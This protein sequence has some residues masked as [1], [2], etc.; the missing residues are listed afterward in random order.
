[1]NIPIF[2]EHVWDIAMTR[3]EEDFF[4][5]WRNRWKQGELVDLGDNVDYLYKYLSR[6]IKKPENVRDEVSKVL[7]DYRGVNEQFTWLCERWLSDSYLLDGDYEA[8]LNAHPSMKPGITRTHDANHLLNVKRLVGAPVVATDLLALVGPKISDWGRAN[9]LH[10]VAEL[11]SVLEG[12]QRIPGQSLVLHWSRGENSYSWHLF[13]GVST[14]FDSVKLEKPFYC[15]YGDEAIGQF[16]AIETRDAENRARRSAG[17]PHIGEGWVSETT[18]FH[19]VK[20]AF[21][22]TD[23]LHHA[24]PPWLGRQ[25]LDIFIPNFK[26]AIEYQGPQHDRPIE[27]FGGQDQ[28]QETKRRDRIKFRK[29]LNNGVV[30]MYVREGYDLE[31]IIKQLK[32]VGGSV[33]DPAHDS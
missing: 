13:P 6:N 5:D 26:V 31:A 32:E 8:A 3:Q 19:Q 11:E 17:I 18:L 4:D 15:Y 2:D 12:I 7:A 25:H 20:A 14:W 21:P 29:C 33:I 22:G 23:V 10:V 1:M 24:Q 16:V 30:L 27:F 28:L 9:I